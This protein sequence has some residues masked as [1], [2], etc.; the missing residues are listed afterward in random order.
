[1]SNDFPETPQIGKTAGIDFRQQKIEARSAFSRSPFEN[2]RVPS[3]SHHGQRSSP[4][5]VRG[6]SCPAVDFQFPSGSPPNHPKPNRPRFIRP[7]S[8]GSPSLGSVLG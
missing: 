3:M 5:F 7:S 1:L 2:R 6:R 8:F 4:K